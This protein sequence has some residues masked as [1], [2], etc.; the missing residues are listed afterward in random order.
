MAIS[1]EYPLLGGEN[2]ECE[3]ESIYSSFYEL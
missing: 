3:T 1:P 2:Y